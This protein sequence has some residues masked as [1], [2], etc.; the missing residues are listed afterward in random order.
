MLKLERTLTIIQYNPIILQ[1]KKLGQDRVNVTSQ[2][3]TTTSNKAWTY[4]RFSNAGPE[5][6]SSVYYAERKMRG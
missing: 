4:T 3:Y 5:A 2:G 1:M 6:L